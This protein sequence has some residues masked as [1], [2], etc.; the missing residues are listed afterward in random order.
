MSDPGTDTIRPV[1]K[2]YLEIFSGCKG[3]RTEAIKAWPAFGSGKWERLP[4]QSLL[5]NK[6]RDGAVS[7]FCLV[8]PCYVTQKV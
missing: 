3:N 7:T 2:Q 1:I 5:E 4:E 6:I 8:G